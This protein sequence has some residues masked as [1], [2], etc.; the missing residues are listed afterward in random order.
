VRDY[1]DRSAPDIIK[2]IHQ[3]VLLSYR[4]IFG[5][6]YQARD[7]FINDFL[8]NASRNPFRGDKEFARKLIG[9]PR[10]RKWALFF[11]R[12]FRR[13]IDPDV[14]DL[15]R[16]YWPDILVQQAEF[17]ER[18]RYD[19]IIDF[20][21]FGPRLLKLQQDCSSQSPASIWDVW[22]DRRD[23]PQ[24]V[25]FWAVLIFGIISIV[26]SILQVVLGTIQVYATRAS[27]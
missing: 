13:P 2:L 5:S 22:R 14:Q 18:D 6:K 11:R 3:E 20:R 23:R 17:K 15:P 9:P 1:Y 25:A 27:I 12:L 7:R 16:E 19:A 4:L 8:S 26:L 10:K 24:W 21:M